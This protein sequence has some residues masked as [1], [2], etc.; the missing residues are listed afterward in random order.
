MIGA[1][2]WQRNLAL[3][4]EY[5][6]DAMNVL[7]SL[8]ENLRWA[9]EPGS[10]TADLAVTPTGKLVVFLVHGR[11]HGT[12]ETV[13]RFLEKAGPHEVIILDE[14]A[15]SGQTLLE[16]L[17]KHISDNKYAVVLLTGDDVGGVKGESDQRPRARQNVVFELGWFYGQLGRKNVAVLCKPNVEQPSDIQ[18]L[19]YIAL[20]SE[21]RRRLV[22]ELNAAGFDYDF[23]RV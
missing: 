10:A 11:D 15:D 14:Q 3:E 21:W 9:K 4:Y 17:E 16:K 8:C 23:G 22:R 13:A 1:R 18:G 12:R 7:T 5:V 2:T 20:D 19:V 6:Q